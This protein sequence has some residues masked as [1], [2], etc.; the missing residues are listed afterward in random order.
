MKDKTKF[1]IILGLFF[2]VLTVIIYFT[3]SGIKA[4]IIPEQKEFGG[5][6]GPDRDLIG[7]TGAPTATTTSPLHFPADNNLSAVATSTTN[8]KM[9]LAG[10]DSVLFTIDQE[11]A[12]TTNSFYWQITGSIEDDCDTIAT[13]TTD[14]NY[15]ASKPL[16]DN[17]HWYD[18]SVAKFTPNGYN[19]NGLINQTANATGTSFILNDVIWKCLRVDYRGASTTILMQMRE[20]SLTSPF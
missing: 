7:T 5:L 8:G 16:I 6:A 1:I 12:S 18:I 4:T 9:L 15:D 10:T 2:V 11:T 19:N 20:K 3:G 13:S 17:I 14:D